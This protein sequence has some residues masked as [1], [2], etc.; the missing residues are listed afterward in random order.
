MKPHIF[1][2]VADALF[3]AVCAFFL[4]LGILR[5][6]HVPS[7]AA[8]AI[9]A[10]IGLSIGGI[11]LLLGLS[12]HRKKRK[13]FAEEGETRALMLH[14]AL[15]KPER[16]AASLVEAFTADGR[17][18]RAAEDGIEAGEETLVPL[19][20]MEPISA[21]AVARLLQRFEARPFTLC[22]NAISP[23]GEELLSSFGKKFMGAEEVFALFQRTETMPHP[24]ILAAPAKPT[25]RERTK[26]TFSKKN[27]RPFF[28]SGVLLLLMSLFVLF[29]RYYLITG[30]ILLILSIFIRIF[31]Y[32]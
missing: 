18:A 11:A 17:E 25:P 3:Y 8:L 24:R 12:R 20:T 1:P 9:S 32:S 29:P 19:F 14:L 27:A 28:V 7:P 6:L 22:G 5:Y 4:P 30:G 21:D 2:V 10:L 26:R 15:E 31:G 23:K 13:K 16:V